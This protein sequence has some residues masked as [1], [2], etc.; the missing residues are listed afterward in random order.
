[1]NRTQVLH[2]RNLLLLGCTGVLLAGVDYHG[3]STWLQNLS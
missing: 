2:L 1:M 3:V